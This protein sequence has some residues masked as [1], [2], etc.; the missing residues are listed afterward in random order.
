VFCWTA[1]AQDAF[2]KLKFVITHAS[3][4]ALPNFAR[5]FILETNASCIGI[6][7]ILSQQ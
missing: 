1:L 7:A 4:L 5:P 2:A 6:V 3:V